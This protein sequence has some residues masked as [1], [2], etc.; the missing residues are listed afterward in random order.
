MGLQWSDGRGQGIFSWPGQNLAPAP[1]SCVTQGN[2]LT[3]LCLHFLLKEE[4]DATL[5]IRQE[6]VGGGTKC[7]GCAPL[8]S[9]SLGLPPPE[10]GTGREEGGMVCQ[11]GRAQE[12]AGL[13][14]SLPTPPSWV[15]VSF[16]CFPRS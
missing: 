6:V 7:F 11:V 3:S 15:I 13:A 2:D 1:T 10:Q 14:S 8:L 12:W 16:L 9:P 5:F 4:N